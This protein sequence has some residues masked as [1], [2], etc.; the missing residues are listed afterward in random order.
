[1]V[2][3]GNFKQKTI[4]TFHIRYVKESLIY[5]YLNTDSSIQMEQHKHIVWAIHLYWKDKVAGF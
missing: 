3:N 4:T 2:L 5:V 1:M